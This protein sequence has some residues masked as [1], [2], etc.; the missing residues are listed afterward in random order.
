[1]WTSPNPKVPIGHED[2]ANLESLP[3]ASVF[4]GMRGIGKSVVAW[5]LARKFASKFDARL[6]TKPCTVRDVRELQQ[7]VRLRPYQSSCKVVVVPLHDISESAQ[8]SLLRI[9]EDVPSFVKIILLSHQIDVVSTIQSRC[10]VFHLQRLTYGNVR[11]V[12]QSLGF[13]RSRAERW[14]GVCRGSPGLALHMADRSFQRQQVK[15]YRSHIADRDVFALAMTSL[16]MDKE[17]AYEVAT[18]TPERDPL[19]KVLG[20]HLTFATALLP[21]IV[22]IERGG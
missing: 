22:A 15:N 1:M 20:S 14:A 13:H 3:P 21:G 11:R 9:L 4:V 8:N 10:W 12:L 7:W 17:S 19:F 5:H 18:T 16:Q 6:Y 2:V